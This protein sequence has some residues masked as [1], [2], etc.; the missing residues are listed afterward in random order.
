MIENSENYCGAH[1]DKIKSLKSM[2]YRWGHDMRQ[3]DHEFGDNVNLELSK[4]NKIFKFNGFK[5][6]LINTYNYF[7]DKCKNRPRKDHIKC[8]EYV[9]YRSD[10][11][12]K[13]CEYDQYR[14]CTVDFIKNYFK[15]CPICIV[16]HDDESV[17]HFHVFVIPCKEIDGQYKFVGSMFC[18]KKK[19]LTDLQSFYAEA[20]KSCNLRR[21]KIKSKDKHKKISEYYSEQ[22]EKLINEYEQIIEHNELVVERNKQLLDEN[23]KKNEL[24]ESMN[25]GLDAEINKYRN[26][27]KDEKIEKFQNSIREFI[28]VLDNYINDPDYTQYSEIF[29]FCLKLLKSI[30][31]KYNLIRIEK[32]DIKHDR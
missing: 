12:D 24:L 3:E 31:V 32:N 23:I 14:E 4:N 22:N 13:Q 9:F 15:D 25:S 11:F 18:E 26:I 16:E 19:M 28:T 27:D 1:M 8:L 5:D 10:C 30:L 21:G 20:C 6:N 2:S 29:R 7:F 17:Q